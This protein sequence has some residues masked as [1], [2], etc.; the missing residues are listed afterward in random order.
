[1][2]AIYEVLIWPLWL[3]LVTWFPYFLW[4]SHSDSDDLVQVDTFP[5]KPL[6]RCFILLSFCQI[7]GFLCFFFTLHRLLL[8]SMLYFC[9]WWLIFL[10]IRVQG[11]WR[12]DLVCILST[13]QNP[14]L[15][16]SVQIFVEWM[17]W[18]LYED[19]YIVTT[20]LFCIRMYQGLCIFSYFV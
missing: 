2:K 18:I 15:R 20:L 1:M 10:L 14:C 4:S 13:Q 17:T 12:R 6:L 11:P 19:Y 5:S 16:A 3:I 7:T 8:W 9:T